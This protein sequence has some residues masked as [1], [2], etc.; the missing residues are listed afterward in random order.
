MMKLCIYA[1]VCYFGILQSEGCCGCCGMGRKKSNVIKSEKFID[2]YV[3][4]PRQFHVCYVNC[5]ML[6]IFL[7]VSHY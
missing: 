6:Q 3:N 4:D 7:Q 2:Y 1:F 5:K